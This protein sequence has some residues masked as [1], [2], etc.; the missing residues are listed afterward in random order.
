MCLYLHLCH[1][2]LS[3]WCSNNVENLRGVKEAYRRKVLHKQF[4]ES[5][6]NT[7]LCSCKCV[8][9]FP[10][11]WHHFFALNLMGTKKSNVIHVKSV[12]QPL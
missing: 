4:L 10:L 8:P 9:E 12:V 11:A 7:D 3:T 5:S 6:I 2:N 1:A